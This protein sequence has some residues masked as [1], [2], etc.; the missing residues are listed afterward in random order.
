MFLMLLFGALSVLAV[1]SLLKVLMHTKKSST[2]RTA[3]CR[4]MATS[5]YT[6]DFYES[7]LKPGTKYV[8]GIWFLFF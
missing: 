1:P 4:Y 8:K 6:S 2:D 5:L 3:Y 7:D